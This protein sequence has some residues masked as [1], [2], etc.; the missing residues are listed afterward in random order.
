MQ[1]D[2]IPWLLAAFGLGCLVVALI[3]RGAGG[4]GEAAR[5]EVG[6]MGMALRGDLAQGQRDAF[7]QVMAGNAALQAVVGAFRT[8]ITDRLL[9]SAESTRAALSEFGRV[10]TAQFDVLTARLRDEGGALRVEVGASLAEMRAG[11]EQKLNEMRQAV[12][13][14]LQ[15]ALEKQVGESFERVAEQFAAVQQAIGQV[16]AVASQV[17]DLKRLFSN[18]KSRGGWGEAQVDA[19]LDEHLPPGSYERNKRLREGSA[20]A[21]D[22]ALRIP[23][24]GGEEVWLPIDAKFPTEDYDRLLLA[25]EAGDRDSELLARGQL[26]RRIRVEA[27]SIAAKYLVPPRTVEYAVLYLP[28]D[29]LFAEV[30]RVP[31]L[32]Q[33]LRNVVH[34]V[35]MGPTLLP[36]FLHAVRVGHLT[37]SLERRASEIGATLSAVR[38]E[39]GNLGRALDGLAKKAAVL[40][41]GIEDTQVRTRAVGRALRGVD[42]IGQGEADRILGLDAPTLALAEDEE[43]LAS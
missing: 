40:N 1:T 24:R 39:W 13:E 14:K 16:Q 17:G 3:L 21:V 18:V 43:A 19:M 4:G 25:N 29:G 23:S 15:A 20:E 8:E 26:E 28:T 6:A 33:H 22:F 38:S 7:A 42:G 12:D 37:L 10:Q 35:V 9:A 32:I 2:L 36:A 41:K 27:A 5:Q 11:N 31:G 34:V 30:A